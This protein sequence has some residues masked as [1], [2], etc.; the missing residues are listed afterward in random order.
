MRLTALMIVSGLGFGAG[1]ALASPSSQEMD[2][3]AVGAD[4]SETALVEKI[5]HLAASVRDDLPLH[6]RLQVSG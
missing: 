4:L 3:Q 5:N 2:K 6:A 1:V